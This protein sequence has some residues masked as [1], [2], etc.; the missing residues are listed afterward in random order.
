MR[1]G[2]HGKRRGDIDDIVGKLH[3][4]FDCRHDGGHDEGSDGQVAAIDRCEGARFS[5]VMIFAVGPLIA[6]PLT[7]GETA[8]TGAEAFCSAAVMPGTARIGSTLR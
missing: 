7:M 5:S 2:I 3:L 8:M 1:C 4:M 6:A